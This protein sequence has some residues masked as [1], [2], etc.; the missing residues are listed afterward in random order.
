M[1]KDVIIA[2]KGLQFGQGEEN[3][4]IETI[5]PGT[6]SERNGAHYV[7][8]DEFSEGDTEPTKNRLKFKDGVLEIIKKGIVNVHM[9]FEEGKKNIA[10]YQ[11]PYGVIVIGLDTS[12]IR[13]VQTDNRIRLDVDYTLEANYEFVADCRISL[14]I[15][16]QGGRSFELR[17]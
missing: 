13:C 8:F 7:L 5:Q 6:Y 10:N 12:R 16:E 9:V 1:T 3:D 15:K 4:E 17:R 2:I 11:T 14:D